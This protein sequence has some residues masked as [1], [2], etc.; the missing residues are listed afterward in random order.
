MRKFNIIFFRLYF[1]NFS[2]VTYY[3]EWNLWTFDSINVIL[4]RN[5]PLWGGCNG[6]GPPKRDVVVHWK[7]DTAGIEPGAWRSKPD[8]LLNWTKRANFLGGALQHASHAKY[9]YVAECDPDPERTLRLPPEIP[10]EMHVKKHA[11]TAGFC[12][13]FYVKC[14]LRC[15]YV[16]IFRSWSR[17]AAPTWDARSDMHVAWCTWDAR[18]VM[19]V[20][21]T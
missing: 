12:M 15:K 18:S 16:V 14:H 19:H 9:N 21:C 20:R 2:C 8:A 17:E 11:K 1:M 10:R 6:R 7:R 3:T 13:L 4:I 5:P